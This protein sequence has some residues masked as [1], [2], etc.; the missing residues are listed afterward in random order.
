LSPSKPA[1]DVYK[2]TLNDDDET[3]IAAVIAF[4][5]IIF[6][7]PPFVPDELPSNWKMILTAWLNGKPIVV[8]AA[9]NEER[10]LQFIEQDLVYKLPWG[11][12]AVRVRGLAHDDAVG[13]VF[14]L[15]DFELGVAV[16][17]VET[18]SLN[19]SATVLMRSGFSSRSAAIKAVEDTSADFTTVQEL[20]SWLRSET[21]SEH[22]LREEWPTPETSQLWQAFRQSFS[23]SSK[24]TW[25]RSSHN[26]AVDWVDG[27]S[28]PSGTPLRAVQHHEGTLL[29]QTLDCEPAGSLAIAINL[30]RK[31]LLLVTT[32]PKKDMVT[33][34]YLGPDDLFAA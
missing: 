27:V 22:S 17:A 21:I 7:I 29:L 33:L 26:I 19:R 18:G 31:G 28:P 32:S 24:Q 23:P 4:A 34:D 9:G 14:T 16:A 1:P 6:Q 5:E 25:S 10:V 20:R 30:T 15:S 3:A 8:L 13:E 12:E 2:Q 11:M